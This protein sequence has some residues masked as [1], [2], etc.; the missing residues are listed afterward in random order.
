MSQPT[1]RSL[2]RARAWLDRCDLVA[3][4]A[5]EFD[6]VREEQPPI[7]WGEV[8]PTPGADR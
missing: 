7:L 1:E 8:D 3:A 5:A 4:L 6:K 2:E